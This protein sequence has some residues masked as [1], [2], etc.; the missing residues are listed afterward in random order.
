MKEYLILKAND[1][2]ESLLVQ[3]NKFYRKISIVQERDL[4][5][6]KNSCGQI[7]IED[8]YEILLKREVGDKIRVV[9]IEGE[10]IVRIY[11]KC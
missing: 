6:F 8:Q 3:I 4:P 5:S 10:T 11:F 9:G 2:C 7:V 1:K